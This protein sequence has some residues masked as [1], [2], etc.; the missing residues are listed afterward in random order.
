MIEKLRLC[1]CLCAFGLRKS[2]DCFEHPDMQAILTNSEYICRK[3]K[4][5]L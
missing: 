3:D 4:T 2:F 5:N 1:Y